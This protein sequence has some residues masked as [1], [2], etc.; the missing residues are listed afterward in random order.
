MKLAVVSDTHLDQPSP[1]FMDVYERFLA[2]AD[3]LL[4]CGDFT[5]PAVL[6]FLQ[7]HPRFY[8]VAGNMDHELYDEGLPGKRELDLDGVRVGMVHGWGLGGDLVR[9]V[10]QV[11]GEGFDLVCFG[12]THRY[13]CE[14]SGRVTVLNPGSATASRHGPPSLALV[15]VAPDKSLLVERIELSLGNR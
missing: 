10:P 5:G 6:W 7:G 9:G 3:V 8:G 11:F 2:P 13:A 4:H 14:R 15:S 12:H 1:W